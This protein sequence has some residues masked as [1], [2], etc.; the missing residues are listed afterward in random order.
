MAAGK[1]RRVGV[2]LRSSGNMDVMDVLHLKIELRSVVW[3]LSLP[4]K[5]GFNKTE[6]DMFLHASNASCAL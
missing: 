4:L 6:A 5:I 1:W 2:I 3:H